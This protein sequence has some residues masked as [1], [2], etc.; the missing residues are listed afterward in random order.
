[1]NPA[2]RIIILKI[3]S[4]SI[5]HGCERGISFKILNQL[6]AAAATLREAGYKVI[7]VTSGAMRLGLAKLGRETI[8]SQDTVSFKQ[9]LTAVG[10]IELMDAYRE[11]FK[12]YDAHVGQVLITHKGLDDTER[13]ETIGRTLTKMFEIDIVPIVNANDTVSSQELIYGDNDSLSARIAVLI[14]AERLIILSDVE[15]LYDKDPNI[16]K[17]AK[18][19]QEVKDISNDIKSMASGASSSAGMGGMRS[20]IE[21]V[22]IC[23][24]NHIPVDILSVNKANKIPEL[25]IKQVKNLG[26]H[27]LVN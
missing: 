14:K 21:A 5:T 9:A 24:D 26:T 22:Q 16:H 20:K 15:G 19:I 17:D 13:N 6:A 4:S 25:V 2:L 27:F 3:G 18:L 11:V 23:V 12:H 10:Q 8:P 1:M 7:I